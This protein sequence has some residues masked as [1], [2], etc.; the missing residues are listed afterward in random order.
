MAETAPDVRAMMWWPEAEDKNTAA[1]IMHC[2][3]TPF[4]K[5]LKTI[6]G[7][8]AA[9]FLAGFTKIPSEIQDR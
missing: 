1:G 7:K 4:S 2:P 9:F 6:G 3:G 5:E 8:P